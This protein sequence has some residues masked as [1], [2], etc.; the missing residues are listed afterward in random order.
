MST[1]DGLMES[2]EEETLSSDDDRPAM[3]MKVMKTS[4]SP[5][6]TPQD[7]PCTS[8][9]SYVPVVEK[10]AL[11]APQRRRRGGAKARESGRASA[12]QT[13]DASSPEWPPPTTAATTTIVDEAEECLAQ[14]LLMFLY[15]D[16]RL[17]SATGRINTKFEALCIDSDR[18][19]RAS[20]ADMAQLDGCGA[21]PEAGG[22][23]VSPG[24]IMA[25]LLV[26]LRQEVMAQRR[27]AR[28]QIKQRDR[29]GWAGRALSADD[30]DEEWGGSD[31]TDGDDAGV[32][33]TIAD[34]KGRKEF[35][36][37]MHTLIRGYNH[38]LAQDLRGIPEVKMGKM[39]TNPLRRAAASGRKGRGPMTR[40]LFSID[41][42]DEGD[43]SV[44]PSQ[45]GAS[46][47]QEPD[48][49]EGSRRSLD[50][51]TGQRRRIAARL[52][53]KLGRGR[54]QEPTGPTSTSALPAE[55]APGN[56]DAPK[57]GSRR[58][59]PLS[60]ILES[61]ESG[62]SGHGSELVS[63][64]GEGCAVGKGRD[65]RTAASTT[66]ASAPNTPSAGGGR[67]DMSRLF[68]IIESVKGIRN[69]RNF[70]DDDHDDADDGDLYSLKSDPGP[71]PGGDPPN[72]DA[73]GQPPIARR[74]SVRRAGVLTRELTRHLRDGVERY[75]E[76]H[77]IHN[78]YFIPANDYETFAG[79]E[80]VGNNLM[81]L[82]TSLNLGGGVGTTGPSAGGGGV[83]DTER[84]MSE[85]ELL[86]FIA[87]CVES[88]NADDLDFMADFF[89]DETIS[90]TMVKSRARVVWLQDWF[91]ITE[92]VYA[93]SVDE[94]KKRVLVVFR[95]AITRADWNAGFDAAMKK[96]SNPVKE[97]YE[98]KKA[99][100]R[101]HRGFFKYMFR[102][103]KDT[104]TR[105][106]DE[107]ANKVYEYGN[108]MIGS[109]FTVTVNGYSLGGALSILWGFYASTD[110]R[111]TKNG[112]V[113]IFSYGSPYVAGMLVVRG[114]SAALCL[115]LMCSPRLLFLPI[116]LSRVE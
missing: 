6:P 85:S 103:R 7:G 110:D 59:S 10:I 67:V 112:P 90:R 113:K 45:G 43:H 63:D 105:K 89:R 39:F 81:R 31:G 35:E 52:A 48:D 74:G 4:L 5:P 69:G 75:R 58:Q 47:E 36:T 15:A 73:V 106:Y 88:R 27:R 91:P 8:P 104:S 54:P 96:T 61:G 57:E 82:A 76:D 24:Q 18:A 50:S 26:E 53:G 99:F 107:I 49:E 55:W 94:E 40:R 95:G 42:F 34:R 66:A 33:D 84:N 12:R 9:Q 32:L 3:E 60:Q 64:A 19:P 30:D 13:N 77:V 70:P 44:P 21:P 114:L 83:G 111:F 80:D 115:Q 87:K 102:T 11:T 38:M 108:K 101:I 93:I 100:M 28:E 68:D 62:E 22:R 1:D 79:T 37:D 17:L 46:P 78:K 92:C 23:G 86:D 116:F 98:G 25:I 65:E 41:P 97:A 29:A 56:D 109:D 20:A 16:L 14:S 72:G 51:G 2:K 71:R